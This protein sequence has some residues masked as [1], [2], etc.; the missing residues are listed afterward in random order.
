MAG[1]PQNKNDLAR[2]VRQRIDELMQTGLTQK[3][4]ADRCFPPLPD[5]Y[6]SRIASGNTR[7]P[8]IDR[9]EALAAGL[10]MPLRELKAAVLR[11]P[12]GEV[13]GPLPASRSPKPT[14]IL[15][16]ASAIALQT[17]PILGPEQLARLD[18]EFARVLREAAN[19]TSDRTR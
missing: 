19:S 8:G 7:S 17:A 3:A 15:P 4:I 18:T 2:V 16:C 14:P 5:W 11:P 6:L 13:A 10:E 12:R 1:R 9:L